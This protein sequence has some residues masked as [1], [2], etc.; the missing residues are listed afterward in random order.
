MTTENRPTQES[1]DSLREWIEGNRERYS[2]GMEI[3][4]D[5]VQIKGFLKGVMA[6]V[7]H[8]MMYDPK[9][10]DP[11]VAVFEI[12][13]LQERMLGVF[14]DIEFL[15]EFEEKKARYLQAVKVFAG[16][17]EITEEISPDHP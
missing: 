4:N 15:D 17:P 14:E 5:P 6:R 2:S 12:A 8:C 3:M 11:H 1:V 10:N 16:V 13:R 9:E 7:T